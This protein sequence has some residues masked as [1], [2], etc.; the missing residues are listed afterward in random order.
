MARLLI[1]G[2]GI[3]GHAA[4]MRPAAALDTPVARR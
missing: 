2:A 4:A 1:L 3:A